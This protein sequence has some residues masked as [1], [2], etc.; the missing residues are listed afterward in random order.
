MI[1]C[2]LCGSATVP[3][4]VKRGRVSEHS[5]HLHRCPNCRFA[6]VA[7][8]WRDYQTIY[9]QDYYRGRG[10]DPYV[11]FVF[12]SE[13]PDTTI[14]VYEWRGILRNIQHLTSVTADTRW[15][16]FGCGQGGL[17]QYCS[18]KV[19]G[20]YFGFEEGWFDG[21]TSG[22]TLFR[23]R[24][25]LDSAGPFDIITAIEVFEHIEDP[26][27]TLL[28]LRKLLK[29]GGLLF[30]TTG[31]PTP[32]LHRFLE[33]EYVYPEIHISYFEPATLEQLLSR[34]GFLPER[35]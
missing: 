2:K 22:F 26:L 20:R 14:R 35:R 11:D 9:S 10:A 23:E 4:G 16:D 12:E 21:K 6:F 19:S 24:G 13:H 7:D 27:E 30:I 25:A 32:H 5:F 8:P 31:N 33:W 17:L 3:L 1:P 18:R 34:A 29:P 28:W 15:L